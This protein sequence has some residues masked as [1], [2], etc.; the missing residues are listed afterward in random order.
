VTA[1]AA[2]IEEAVGRIAAGETATAL[3]GAHLAAL[4]RAAETL[5]A[6][7]RSE[8]DAALEAAKALDRLP[9]D[10][11][12]PLHGAPLA[13][14]D[15][16]GRAGWRH[17]A[18]LAILAGNVARTTGAAL[19]GLDAAGALDLARLNTVEAALGGEGLNAHTGPVR[20]PWNPDHVTGGSSSGSAAAVASGAVPAAL[21]SDTGGSIR[22]PAAACGLVGL[23]PTAGL[24]G[25]SGV[26]ALSPTLD[27]VGP[28]TR[29]VRD[30]ALMMNA[31]AGHDPG[32]PQSVRR[33]PVDHLAG[34]EDG[35]A[36][37]R[38]G[39]PDRYFLDPVTAPV[40]DRLDAAR[41]LLA[42]EG[43]V[44][45]EV[46]TPGFE[47]A[48]RLAQL[49][50]STEAAAQHAPW[51]ATRARD[52]GPVTRRRLMPGLFQSAG[53]YLRALGARTALARAA[54]EGSFAQ[55]DALLLPVWPCEV[56]TI[57]ETERA[58]ATGGKAAEDTG[59]CARPINML[60]F[61]SVAVPCGLTPNGLPTAFQLVGRPFSE[62]LLLRMARGFER[63]FA[64]LE[65]HA[66][67][68]RV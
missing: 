52:Y 34:I 29:T 12:G 3:A 14:K 53:P 37:L 17:E 56:P 44:L 2:T 43:T 47:T 41:A 58:V 46:E 13:H 67:Q 5:N 40:G 39:L 55:V 1:T 18:G 59:H 26:F 54:L 33:P 35:L 20:N 57:A 66:P 65:D 38:V 42:A 64:F 28:L 21:G 51:L 60:G 24:V 62:P 32:D 6:V 45:R 30:A 15:L 11:R 50:I 25:R 9:A 23:K 19:A 63:A 10:A 7:A 27:T 31:L 16:Y 22:L 61:P 49:I 36:G 8:P 68:V 48:N 4:G